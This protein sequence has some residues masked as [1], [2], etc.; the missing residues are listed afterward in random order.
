MKIYD[1]TGRKE[2]KDQM[3]H[4]TIDM[5]V[6]GS[7]GNPTLTT[8]ILDYE[9]CYVFTERPL[10]IICPGGGYENLSMREGEPIA[11]QF[12]A[13]GYHAA[14]L[15]YSVAPARYPAALLELASAMV[16]IHK[17]IK[18]WHI[19]PDKILVQGSSAGGHL[20]A[21]LGCFWNSEF[22]V[23]E[24]AGGDA[25]LLKPNG[26]ILSYPVITSGEFAHRDSFCALLGNKEET[27]SA[28]MSLENQVTKDTPPTFLWH[29]F[30]DGLVP[31]ENSILFAT[32]LCKEKVPVELHIFPKGA[33]GL[34]LGNRFTCSCEENLQPETTVWI[35]LAQAF[36]EQ[37]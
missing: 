32:A 33:H 29:T 7:V 20:A 9:G 25:G 11:M 14:V 4:E 21:S 6:E 17:H 3:I 5:T 1:L 37:L 10:V 8:Y 13:M 30:A 12:N 19:D 36:I 24:V 28:K 34:G 31:V 18:E 35:E 26:L 2:R 23:N 16:T 22:L 15:H 27:L